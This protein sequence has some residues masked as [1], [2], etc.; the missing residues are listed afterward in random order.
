MPGHSVAIDRLAATR[1]PDERPVGHQRWSDLLFV[2]W[3]LSVFE[4]EPLIPKQL[5]LDTYDGSAWVGLVLFRMSGVRPWWSPPVPGISSFC[6][7]NVRTYVHADG[8]H[9]GV[10]FMSL[11]ASS[12]L[13]VR[14]ARWRWH[15]LYHRAAMKVDRSGS[16]VRYVS[17]RLWPGTVGV[18]GT[19]EAEVGDL[20]GQLDKDVPAGQAVPG[21]LEHFLA[22]RY[23]L[24]SQSHTGRLYRAQVHHQPYPLREAELL[25]CDETFLKA[26]DLQMKS[27]PSHVMFS[28]GVNVDIFKLRPVVG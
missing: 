1:R 3:P 13:A 27:E 22:E 7:T 6:E 23:V 17:E 20:F 21:T 26:A 28:S 5:T 25:K 9:P 2:H 16:C 8:E 10:W 11:D 14:L 19:V 4:L 24:Y 12:S 18:G 15:L